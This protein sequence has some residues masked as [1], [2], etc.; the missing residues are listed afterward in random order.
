[1]VSFFLLGTIGSSHRSLEV[2]AEFST[3]SFHWSEIEVLIFG[4]WFFLAVYMW[5]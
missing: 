2:S 3:F 5:T 1:M 4:S